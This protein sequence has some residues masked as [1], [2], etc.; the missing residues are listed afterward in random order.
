MAMDL[1]HK[2]ELMF[3]KPKE[4]HCKIELFGK[5]RTDDSIDEIVV[6][7]YYSNTKSFEYNFKQ[8]SHFTDVFLDTEIDHDENL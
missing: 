6:D 5:W 1:S 3:M 7:P 8:L 4:A 2:S